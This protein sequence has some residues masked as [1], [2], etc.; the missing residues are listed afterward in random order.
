[1]P[2]SI[3]SVSILLNALS[4]DRLE[5]ID[6]VLISPS[7]ASFVFMSDV[8]GPNA[9]SMGLSFDDTAATSIGTSLPTGLHKPSARDEG[10]NDRFDT[11]VC[12]G[13]GTP[14]HAAPSGSATFASQFGGLNPNGTWRLCIAD[15]QAG[16]IGA[17]NGIS[18]TNF[19]LTITTTGTTSTTTTVTS[20]N[21]PSVATDPVTFTATVA[22]SSPVT[23]GV[24]V[25]FDG[26]TQ[27][28]GNVPVDG[29]GQAT[30]TTSALSAASHTI[31]AVYSGG[32]GFS[33]S[34]GSLTQVVTPLLVV[35]KLADTNDGTCDADCSL[36][37]ALATAPAG[38][39]VR[40]AGGLAGGTIPI[41]PVLGGS[42]LVID[43]DLVI[44]GPPTGITIDGNGF[45]SVFTVTAGTVRISDLTIIEGDSSGSGGGVYVGGGSVTLERL[46]INA[47]SATG[48]G[49]G[50]YNQGTV[51]IV[52]TT[53]RGNSST[54]N[55][56]GA[57]N[58]GTM[59]ILNSSISA[60]VTSTN[61]GGGVFSSSQLTVVNSTI[62]GNTALQGGGI[63]NQGTAQVTNTTITNNTA[64]TAGGGIYTSNPGSVTSLRNSIVANQ[65]GGLDCVE[66]SSGITATLDNNIDS[67][68]S[69]DL[70]G[71]NDQ[72]STEPELGP[73]QDNGGLTFT[74]E[75]SATSPAI[76]GGNDCVLADGC[77]PAVGLT[78]ATDQ[79]GV[80]RPQRF[81]VD[82]GSF[83]RAPRTCDVSDAGDSGPGTLR[84]L[85]GDVDCSEIGFDLGLMGT[86]TI[87]LASNLPTVTRTLAVTGPGVAALTIDRNSAGGVGAPPGDNV[88]TVGSNGNLTVSGISFIG[89]EAAL[90]GE[91]GSDA[92][93]SGV[94]ISG[95]QNTAVIFGGTTLVVRDSTIQGGLGGIFLDASGVA[96][97]TGTTISGNTGAIDAHGSGL[98]VANSTL[99]GNVYGISTSLGAGILA[100]NVTFYENSNNV[101][102]ASTADALG[103]IN[104]VM[105]KGLNANCAFPNG[106]PIQLVASSSLADDTSCFAGGSGGNLVGPT[107][108]SSAGLAD[109]G[110]PTLTV[111]LESTSAAIDHAS[112]PSCGFTGPGT[113]SGVDQRG[114]TRPQG[115]GCDM[116]AFELV[117]TAQTIVFDPL[118]DR[119]YGDAAFTVAATASSNL[120][121]TFSATGNCSVAGNLVTVTTPGPCTI[122]ANQAG[123]ATYAPAPPVSQP[124]TINKAQPTTTVVAPNA[125]YDGQPHGATASTAGVANAPLGPTTI[126]YTVQG[127]NVPLPGAP[128][129]A[130]QYTA[131]GSF[132]GDGNYLPS[133]GSTD[134]SIQG[135]APTIAIFLNPAAPNGQNGWYRTPVIVDVDSSHPYLTPEVRCVMNPVAVPQTFAD[136]PA[137]P[138]PYLPGLSQAPVGT[139]HFYAAATTSDGVASSVASVT[140]KIDSDAPA[141]SVTGPTNG[142]SYIVG[143]VPAAG[144]STTD[145]VSGVATNASLSITG[146]NA[147][148]AGQFTATCSGARDN[149]GNTASASVQYTVTCT[150][151]K[152]FAGLVNVKVNAALSLP[153]QVSV[154]IQQ[155]V[156]TCALG[157]VVISTNPPSQQ[158]ALQVSTTAAPVAWSAGTQTGLDTWLFTVKTSSAANAGVYLNSAYRPL[159][160]S[161]TLVVKLMNG[162]TGVYLK[163]T[164]TAPTGVGTTRAGIEAE[165]APSLTLAP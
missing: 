92:T 61:T 141:V 55:G 145:P 1:M 15:D 121:V 120:P 126:V 160:A 150:P 44:E 85:V 90:V 155:N 21:N 72:P 4:A 99:A 26:V 136:L 5:D 77:S 139:H 98:F 63:Y 12:T 68:G 38:G 3:I 102:A 103:L 106:T 154:T 57:F 133:T 24:V 127:S 93:L 40:F 64:S 8:G 151:T 51:T 18:I 140:F 45:A 73:L 163:L 58:T 135:I 25:F 153:R 39:T 75:I 80:A 144:C 62:S 113:V 118:P 134:Y 117:R 112:S 49:G 67:D 16:P 27:I 79:R 37:E 76:D 82:I 60:N 53:I 56:A 54:N 22:S 123:D 43:D 23:T 143:G 119:T 86:G 128:V 164:G 91:P 84:D 30:L 59:V 31:S 124:F 78:I 148:G 66:A 9:F 114:V 96:Y 158:G 52:D 165:S 146:G 129:L 89:M 83:E 13:L 137:G 29:S 149:A 122:T 69:C 48:A 33:G 17:T 101:Y 74:H 42:T 100:T 11:T 14:I 34:N 107:G 36:R 65:A 47:N 71:P 111:A 20:S 28:S 97:V 130:G 2:G 35:T 6:A 115:P 87:E 131:T 94:R 142:A 110:G 95:S 138:C 105:K 132:A 161:S 32:G 7:G 109:N 50:V 10:S 88:F 116:G 46:F 104:V 125:I 147:W 19:Q 162:R 41:A 152:T 70:T 159:A 81:S 156:T 108:L 157:G